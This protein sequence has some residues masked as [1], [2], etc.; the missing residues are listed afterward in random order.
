MSES[1]AA[2][3]GAEEGAISAP[4]S[5]PPL[6]L[7][8]RADGMHAL[9]LTAPGDEPK[10]GVSI[11]DKERFF[12]QMSH[13]VRTAAHIV[14]GYSDLLVDGTGGVLPSGA[15]EMVG[16]IA[17]SARHLREMVDDLLD[18]TRIDTGQVRLALEEQSLIALVRDTL[19]WLEPQASAKGIEI[20]FLAADV[21]PARTDATR[22]RQILLNLVSNA[23]RFT[24][25]GGITVTLGMAQPD[26]VAIEVTDTGIGMA[27]AELER[28]FD[29]FFQ[30]GTRHGGTG[31]GLAISRR[32]ARLL[33]GDLRAESAPGEGSSFTLTIPVLRPIETSGGRR[34]TPARMR[35]VPAGR[36]A[37]ATGQSPGATS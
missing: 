19:A 20:H 16:R 36:R 18:L 17:H 13:E 15:A 11:A 9:S 8:R 32:L 21:P 35:R 34:S 28:V 23:V 6:D 4:R 24:E 37:P 26:S 2:V 33:G 5:C 10:A 29:E 12:A 7:P 1:H 27:P 14:L 22:L 30:A 3:G 31:L 25:H